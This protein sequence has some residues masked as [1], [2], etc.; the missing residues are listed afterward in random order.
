M[1]CCAMWIFCKD[2]MTQRIFF[3]RFTQDHCCAIIF[4]SRDAKSLYFDFCLL[5]FGSEVVFL[6]NSERDDEV[7]DTTGDDQGTEAG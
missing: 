2:A 7:S 5:T 4:N 3:H 6:L 1:Y